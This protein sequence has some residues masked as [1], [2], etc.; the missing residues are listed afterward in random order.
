[1]YIGMFIEDQQTQIVGRIKNVIVVDGNTVSV[2]F[3]GINAKI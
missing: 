2:T 3:F 1:M